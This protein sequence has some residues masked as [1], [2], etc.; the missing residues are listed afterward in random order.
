MSRASMDSLHHFFDRL[1]NS[2]T[3]LSKI[4]DAALAD[5][6]LEFSPDSIEVVGR[7][8]AWKLF[9]LPHDPLNP[10]L[11]SASL[12]NTLSDLRERY[13]RILL[14]K[15]RAPDGSYEE[16]FVL[17]GESETPKR[18]SHRAGNLDE[19]NPL[20]LHA[21]NPWVEWFASVE[22]RKTI[23]QDV[24]RTFPEIDFFRNV[25]VQAQL[26][27]ILFLYSVEH[28]SIGYRQGMHEL[29]A[30]LYYAVEH[31]SI[32]QTQGKNPAFQ[33]ACSRAWVAAD[34][35]A[36]FNSVM[37]GISRWYEWREPTITDAASLPSSN[38]VH[39]DIPNGQVELKP[40]VAP[41]VQ[42]CNRIQSNLLRST[43]PMLWKHIQ[44]TGIEPQI[45]GIRWLRLLF[46]REFSMPD[47]MRLWDVLF[48]CDPTFELAPWIC[49]A[50]LIRIRNNLLPTDYTGQLTVLLRYPSPP[51]S[52]TSAHHTTLLLRQ[53][54]ALQMS[55]TPSTG[56]S[57]MTENRNLLNIPMEVPEPPPPPASRR[58]NMSKEIPTRRESS[59][60]AP[61]R[62]QSSSMGFP[63]MLARGLMERGESLGIN[64]TLMSA[65][66]ELRRNIPDLAS[67]LVRSPSANY[68]S[69]PLLDERQPE[70]RPPWEPRTRL[71]MER[72]ISSMRSANRRLGDS[73]SWIVDVLLQ[74]EDQ[75]LDPT[76]RKKQKREAL[77]SLSY[78]RDVLLG[79]VTRIEDDRLMGEEELARRARLKEEKK[80]QNPKNIALDI[81]E[82]P[83]KAPVVETRSS[84]IGVSRTRPL[85]QPPPAITSPSATS[86]GP[87]LAPWSYTRSG[88]SAESSSSLPATS[89]PRLPPPTSTSLRGPVTRDRTPSA[90]TKPVR[91]PQDPLGVF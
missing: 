35:W 39:L 9:L 19:N 23:H 82:L 78:V 4:R 53:A 66:S 43:D 8:L 28:P 5:R 15:M 10:Q 30:P 74:D 79:N 91:Q 80:K 65:V 76:T 37:N 67:S 3:T 46:T 1:F 72:D 31:D 17:P 54:L 81:P 70:E 68:P 90:E 2:G 21:Q 48:A 12:I 25:E 47:A 69:F 20:S 73:L 60:S 83:A 57:L 14:E 64:K 6:L 34:S 59:D 38:T 58:R 41:I 86:P 29:L 18:A 61:G 85:S 32:S 27:N 56:V 52:E 88:F 22:L 7:S 45:Y 13:C 40:Y 55:P 62:S 50:M 51:E 77:E 26:T 42:A 36:L 89:L 24:E 75:V 11:S 16:G 84:N 33:E 63:E 87:Q 49:C 71:E 44:S